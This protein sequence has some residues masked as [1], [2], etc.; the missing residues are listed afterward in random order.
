MTN[1]MV[2]LVLAGGKGTR[3]EGLTKKTSKPAVYFGGKY[4]IIDFVLSN[5]ANSNISKIG[6]LTQYES[7]EISNYCSNGKHWGFDGNVCD[8]S[9][10]SPRQKQDGSHWYAG[11]ADAIYQNL[12]WIDEINPKYVLILSSDHIYKMNYDKMLKFTESVD[13]DCTIGCL[14]VEEKDVSRFGILTLDEEQRVKTFIEKPKHSTSRDASMG[15]YIFKWDVLREYLVDDAKKETE[16]D[17][18]KDIIPNMMN[19]NK[20]VYGYPFAGYWRDVGTIESLWRT[21]MDLLD[22]PDALDLYNNFSGFKIYT[23]D[24]KSLPQ[25]IG[26]NA[27]VTN[28]MVNQGSIIFGKVNH[29]VLFT[30]CYVGEGSEIE[31]AV[32]MP[33]VRIGKN[34]KV[35]NCIISPS[36]KIKDNSELV[37]DK[38]CL[39]NR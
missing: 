30:S 37:F 27:R 18:G 12:D 29:S 17:F 14:K 6:V 11:T 8:F 26:P 33:G 22:D 4:R 36:A 2:A 38:V 9:I 5:C 24:T 3:L 7:I 23:E 25:Y 20:K 15:I 35:K 34:C 32:I 16:H 39:V 10:L 21:N 13:A 1:D 31:D 28:S 19:S